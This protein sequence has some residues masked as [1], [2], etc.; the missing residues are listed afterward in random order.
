MAGSSYG[1]V[2]QKETQRYQQL[3]KSQDK[4][5]IL[6][7]QDPEGRKFRHMCGGLSTHNS[8]NSHDDVNQVVLGLDPREDLT[9]AAQG[10]RGSHL[11]SDSQRQTLAGPPQDTYPPTDAPHNPSSFLSGFFVFSLLFSSRWRQTTDST[12]LGR[13]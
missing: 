13:I 3:Q 9:E 6:W 4:R 10:G 5:E 8:L 2:F 12:F 11:L 7:R 1:S